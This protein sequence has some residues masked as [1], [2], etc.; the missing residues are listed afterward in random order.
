MEIDWL[1]DDDEIVNLIL[2]QT[3]AEKIKNSHT[4]V[5]I[6]T[7]EEHNHFSPV[8]EGIVDKYKDL[9]SDLGEGNIRIW[10]CYNACPWGGV[11][12]D[13]YDNS[14][15]LISN[16]INVPVRIKN[17]PEY[18]NTD[19]WE[20]DFLH[21][22]SH[23]IRLTELRKIEDGHSKEFQ[24]EFRIICPKH[25]LWHESNYSL[26]EDYDGDYFKSEGVIQ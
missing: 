10:K 9:L 7:T 25:L 5:R 15:I 8:I 24:K 18:T 11:L 17:P 14:I 4:D 2:N 13:D 26:S 1:K 23:I 19:L 6:L 3:E 20:Y 12:N 21:E 16:R 22:L